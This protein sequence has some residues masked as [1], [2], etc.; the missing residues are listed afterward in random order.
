MSEFWTCGP[1]KE[2]QERREMS[3]FLMEQQNHLRLILE[4]IKSLKK[5]SEVSTDEVTIELAKAALLDAE[6]RL[7][8]LLGVSH[9]R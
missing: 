7:N 2:V 6:S 4:E 5:L 1:F 3:V 9:E 8:L